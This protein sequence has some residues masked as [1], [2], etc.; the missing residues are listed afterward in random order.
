[1]DDTDRRHHHYHH[2]YHHHGIGQL[3]H[4]SG[5]K[6]KPHKNGPKKDHPWE[7]VIDVYLNSVAP[8]GTPDFDIQTC[9]PTQWNEPANNPVVFFFND[10]RNGFHITFRFFDDTNGGAGSDY[11]FVD[12]KDGPVW[13]QWGEYCP[14][15]EA[16]DVFER[17]KRID[18]TTLEVFNANDEQREFQ[19]ALRVRKGQAGSI[20]TL[21]PGGNNM[22]GVSRGWN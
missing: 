8:D 20:V 21:D 5:H 19:Y 22:N 13:S 14:D 10:G 17:L 12:E 2:H 9:L 15:A 18:D 6:S 1:M 3:G 4:A 7:V 11:R 16:H